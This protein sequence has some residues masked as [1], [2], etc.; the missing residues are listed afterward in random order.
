M[1]KPG[2]EEEK[3]GLGKFS[4]LSIKK[5][6]KDE[7]SES[8]KKLDDGYEWQ[9][10][11]KEEKTDEREEKEKVEVKLEETPIVWSVPK[12]SPPIV[13]LPPGLKVEIKEV[14]GRR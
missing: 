8:E 10:M 13:G 1:L 7:E 12:P 6:L 3:V 2:K 5:N 11:D 4:G 9:K 14:Q